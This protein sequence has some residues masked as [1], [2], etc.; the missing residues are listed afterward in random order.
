MFRV[1]VWATSSVF[2]LFIF[3]F[4]YSS[5]KSLTMYWILL[6]LKQVVELKKPEMKIRDGSYWQGA[7]IWMGEK[8]DYK[9]WYKKWI[10]VRRGQDEVLVSLYVYLDKFS[11]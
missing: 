5:I 7:L 10:N 6:G 8:G 2:P 4:T 11:K 9:P 1:N 3:K